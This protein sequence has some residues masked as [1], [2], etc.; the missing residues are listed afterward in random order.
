M[1]GYP[2]STWHRA[3]R[4]AFPYSIELERTAVG[5]DL[6]ADFKDHVR[7]SGTAEDTELTRY[8]NVAARALEDDTRRLLITGTVKEYYDVW[9]W[10]WLRVVQLTR[11]PVVSLSSVKYYDTGDVLQ[12]WNSAHYATDLINEPAR[13][14]IAEGATLTSPNVD[15][16]P[17]AV[18]IEYECGYGAA[19]TDLNPESINA[20]MVKAAYLYGCGRELMMQAGVDIATERCWQNEVRRLTWS[21]L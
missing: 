16:R 20:I 9:P 5:A 12:T 21:I 3:Q 18:V 4:C 14:V 19:V 13:I 10:D 8:L 11:A 1:T 15:Q 2:Q 7:V 17:N 6:L